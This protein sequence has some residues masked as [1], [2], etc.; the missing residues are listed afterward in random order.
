MKKIMNEIKDAFEELL[1]QIDGIHQILMDH[2]NGMT[3]TEQE[4]RA[5]TC[6]LHE[7]IAMIQALRNQPI[8]RKNPELDHMFSTVEEHLSKALNLT[9]EDNRE[10]IRQH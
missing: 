7:K 4:L 8:H 1:V 5:V 3:I 2:N 10:V 6:Q 9:H